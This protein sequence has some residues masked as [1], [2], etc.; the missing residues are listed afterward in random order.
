MELH[1]EDAVVDFLVKNGYTV[2][3]DNEYNI[4]LNDEYERIVVFVTP[5]SNEYPRSGLVMA[6][7]KRCFDKLSSVYYARHLPTT[8]EEGEAILT[9]LAVLDEEYHYERANG[10]ERFDEETEECLENKA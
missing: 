5:Y 10:Y 6:E 4:V 3:S 7:S 2:K 9:E 1:T 8:T